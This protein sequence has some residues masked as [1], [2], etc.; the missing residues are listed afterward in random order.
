MYIYVGTR[1]N[2]I[3][4]FRKSNKVNVILIC[5]HVINKPLSKLEYINHIMYNVCIIYNLMYLVDIY[6]YILSNSSFFGKFM[7]R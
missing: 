6:I 3:I 5:N 7:N 2:I 4:Y 1:L